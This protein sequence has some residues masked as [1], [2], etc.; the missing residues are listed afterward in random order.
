M[1]TRLMQ[2][3]A[4]GLAAQT[5]MASDMSDEDIFKMK[6]EKLSQSLRFFDGMHG[7]WVGFNRGLYKERNSQMEKICMDERARNSWIEA[8][9]VWLGIDDIPDDVDFFS[10]LGDMLKLGANLTSCKFRQP[11]RDIEDHC[12]PNPFAI[13]TDELQPE[14]VNY[15]S[16]VNGD[17]PCKFGNIMEQYQ[18]NA[19]VLIAKSGEMAEITKQ[20]PADNPDALMAQSMTLGED[21]GT[22]LRIGIDFQNP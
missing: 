4:L 5:A 15:D 7:A 13:P 17:K 14:E 1:N 22:F 21:V 2:V 9:S 20:F 10:G 6:H 16:M 3:V 18:K 12:W 8:Y 11:V 19:F